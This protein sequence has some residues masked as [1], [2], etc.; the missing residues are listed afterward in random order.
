MTHLVVGFV[1]VLAVDGSHGDTI[2]MI[3]QELVLIWYL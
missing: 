1:M 3:L 2:G